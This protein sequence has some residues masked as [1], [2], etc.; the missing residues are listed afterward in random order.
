M[1]IEHP[2]GQ[3]CLKIFCFE[4]CGGEGDANEKEG[5]QVCAKQL[6]HDPPFQNHDELDAGL[7]G[8]VVHVPHQH[9][10]LDDVQRQFQLLLHNNILWKKTDCLDVKFACHN[11][12]AANLAKE[13]CGLVNQVEGKGGTCVSKG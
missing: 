12:Y 11:P 6:A 2:Y 13:L 7:T 3:S 4:E 1:D 10:L 9:P 8:L 5:W